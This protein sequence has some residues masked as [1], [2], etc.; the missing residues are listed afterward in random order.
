MQA[1]E[2]FLCVGVFA[3]MTGLGAH[4]CGKYTVAAIAGVVASG[5]FAG[6]VYLLADLYL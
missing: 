2:L 6:A 1:Y 3:F 4:F 5:G